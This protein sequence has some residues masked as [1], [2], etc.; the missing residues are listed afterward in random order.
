MSFISLIMV[1]IMIF[2]FYHEYNKESPLDSVQKSF[3][4]FIKEPNIRKMLGLNSLFIIIL[5]NFPLYYI[6]IYFR[7]NN[8]FPYEFFE[9]KNIITT[10]GI[11]NVFLS[12]VVI[13]Y[14]FLPYL[15]KY[16]KEQD[17]FTKY[18]LKITITIYLIF[19]I[20]FIEGMFYN[21]NT[22]ASYLLFF[23]S[24]GIQ[25][26]LRTRNQ[27][28]Q[29]KYWWVSIISIFILIVLPFCFSQGLIKRTLFNNHIGNFEVFL[30]NQEQKQKNYCLLLKSNT[31]YYLQD[32]KTLEIII[33]NSGSSYIKYEI[34][35]KYCEIKHDR[36]R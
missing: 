29:E 9:Y 10:I 28:I 17:K 2:T 8:F 19:F 34:T 36:S 26:F 12:L 24:I 35:K 15:L 30:I 23:I 14:F 31:S 27:N 33:T 20:V 7:K 18:L 11:E 13:L 6:W 16:I 3:I 4:T 22:V 1:V 21:F 5:M 25:V 32:D